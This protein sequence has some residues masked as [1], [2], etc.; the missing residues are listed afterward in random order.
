MD[1]ASKTAVKTLTHQPEER[2]QL[3]PGKGGFAQCTFADG[4]ERD[5]EEVPNLLLGLAAAGS[6]PPKSQGK[7]KAK[8]KP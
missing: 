5:F 8:P 2:A 1:L 7:A 6:K 4:Q 3:Y